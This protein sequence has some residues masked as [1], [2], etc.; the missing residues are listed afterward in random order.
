M[1]SWRRNSFNAKKGGKLNIHLDYSIHPKL[2]LK[3]N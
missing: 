1:A 3:E 2:N